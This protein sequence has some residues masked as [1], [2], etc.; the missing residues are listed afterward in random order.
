MTL[1]AVLDWYVVA[2]KP[3]GEDRAVRSL[4]RLGLETFVPWHNVDQRR[5]GK[6]MMVR[7]RLF[8]GYVFTGMRR[9]HK[10]WREIG[11]SYGVH[12]VV[13]FGQVPALI[14]PHEI[15][16][17]Q[18]GSIMGAFDVHPHP[19]GF[20]VGAEVK[21]MDGAFASYCGRIA[22]APSGDRIIVMFSLFGRPAPIEMALDAIQLVA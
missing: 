2:T 19:T 9:C 11:E 8:P 14:P 22:A 12:A 4:Q 20:D 15:G 1:P 17:L 7:R 5:G 21:A 16:E 6:R 13:A 3:K 18:A 10:P